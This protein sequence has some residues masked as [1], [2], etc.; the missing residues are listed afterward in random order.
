MTKN[1]LIKN[2]GRLVTM[3]KSADRTG[4]LGV[5]E[6]A[7]V[8]VKDGKIHDVGLMDDLPSVDSSVREIDA[9]GRVVMPGLIDCHT[10]LV[11]AGS[12]Q[13]EFNMRSEGKTYKE[14]AEAGGG[15][16]STVRSTREALFGDLYDESYARAD[17]AL[18]RGI[19]TIEIKTG[20]GLGLDAELKMA[21]IIGELYNN[22]PIDVIGT[23]LGAHVVPHEYID[24]RFKYIEIVK[25]EMLP[26]IAS[27]PWITGCDV[28]VEDIAFRVEEA[29]E[30][31]KKAKD[32]GL[33]IHLHVDQF[34]DV[35]GG[36]LAAELGA[37]SADHLDHTSEKGMQEM[38]KAGVVGVVLPG[39]SFFTG[40]GH[41]PDVRK[42]VENDLKVAIATDYNPGTTPSLDLML[43]ASIAVTQM[44]MSCDEALLAITRNAARAL[45]LSDRGVIKKGTRADLILLDAPDEYYP[46][47]RYGANFV[48]SVIV[49]GNVI[50]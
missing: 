21:D 33:S 1:L 22:H 34:G 15:I 5:I 40:G 16:M 2:I 13:N 30:I 4:N 47:Y 38:A 3:D 42:M 24:D 46:L 25:E 36:E 31:A 8:L 27:K 29:R 11:H 32:F 48:K 7:Y 23:F 18:S 28:F 49:D 6:N 19:T 50:L 26:K 41:Y 10:H 44:K 45:G 35:R 12:R 9:A 20:Y 39:A 37:F 14:I 17:E 43:N